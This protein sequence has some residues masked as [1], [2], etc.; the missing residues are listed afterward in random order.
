MT[1]TKEFEEPVAALKDLVL[2]V[3]PI[4][5]SYVVKS[6]MVK[7]TSK[8]SAIDFLPA[9][10]KANFSP[11]DLTE[12]FAQEYCAA[13]G[14]D[15]ESSSAP[16]TIVLDIDGK[17][18][19]LINYLGTKEV[20][21]DKRGRVHN[22][23]IMKDKYA[24]EN[25]DDTIQIVEP[26]K[27]AYLMY[28]PIHLPY[29]YHAKRQVRAGSSSRLVCESFYNRN[30]KD[31]NYGVSSKGVP[32]LSCQFA[33]HRN[34]DLDSQLGIDN[35]NKCVSHLQYICFLAGKLNGKKTWIGPLV[36]ELSG[37]WG[38]NVIQGSFGMRPHYKYGSTV[39]EI[40]STTSGG[41]NVKTIEN[42][43]KAESAMVF[44]E[45]DPLLIE[46]TKYI[47]AG[48]RSMYIKKLSKGSVAEEEK[49]ELV[50]EEG[51]TN[52]LLDEEI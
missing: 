1:F 46:A 6:L 39:G 35:N 48:Y 15:T 7:D 13:M 23:R 51:T 17:P 42:L 10:I 30:P 47:T 16:S 41:I 19:R 50:E 5:K 12:E 29:I 11:E 44:K 52:E 32:C 24:E 33:P 18:R 2:E 8:K 4:F 45:D 36:W 27:G 49:E 9:E 34:T 22:F 21:V 26:I 40:R 25:K 31:D 14:I 28:S 37:K 38:Y 20:S 3:G 43:T